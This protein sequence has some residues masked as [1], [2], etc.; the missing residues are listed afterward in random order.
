[1]QMPQLKAATSALRVGI[2]GRAL[3]GPAAGVR[4]YVSQLMEAI[5]RVS[6][7]TELFA[8]GIEGA[9]TVPQGVIA[10]RSRGS[11][12]TNAGWM[13]T[14]LPL[15]VRGLGLH[16][17]HAPAYTAPLVGTPPV[18]LTVHDV[19][20][21][22]RPEDYPYHLDPVRRWFYR[23][24]ARSASAI[25][26]DSAFSAAEIEAA[27]S[28]PGDRI[29]VVPLAADARFSPSTAAALL[30][31]LAGAPYVLHV[32]DLHAR[33]RAGMLLDAVIDVRSRHA[34]LKQLSLVLIGRDHGEGAQVLARAADA[35]APDAA[36][37]LGHRSDEDLVAA[38]RG[39]S[40][41]VYASRYEGFGLP[42]LEALA[43]GTPVVATYDASVPE[44][45]GDAG[46]LVRDATA[47]RFADA[48][49]AVLLR[50]EEAERLR[51]AGPRRAAQFSWD[52][53]ALDTIAVY[54]RV[55]NRR[56]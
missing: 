42:V 32:G 35:G 19:S 2:D 46:C 51:R 47:S 15:A 17:F 22:R 56:S 52:R 26:T 55:A 12:P 48:L 44:I 13:L 9:D 8:V 37:Y 40:A 33:R 39:A 4:R 23:A 29:T 25:I 24:S 28:I 7:S 6:P 34:S 54:D 49:S 31:E 20:Y 36:R 30:P 11:L 14:G 50:P 16:V 21:A 5:V 41:F 45:V 3:Y 53:T 43:C 1:M 18:V 27:Y 10:S 38:L